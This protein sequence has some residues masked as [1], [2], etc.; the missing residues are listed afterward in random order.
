MDGTLVDNMRFHGAAWQK[1]L[2]ENGVETDASEFL[3]KTAG[4]TNREIIPH[5]FKDA[6]EERLLELGLRKET[7]YRELFLSERRAIHGAI[8]FLEASKKL[9]VKMAV[10][11]AAP[12]ANMEFVL[13]GLDLRRFFDAITTAADVSNGKPNPEVFLKSAEKLGIEPKHCLVFEDAVNGFAA[14]HRAGMKS[15]G[16]A[17]VNSIEDILKLDSVVEAHAD[18]S[19]L[20]PRELIE[21]YLPEDETQTASG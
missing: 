12:V 3:V 2:A 1:M 6:T 17:T 4:K 20:K 7:I 13:D 9:G 11:T 19:N 21:K 10:A 15:V 8:E 5:F 18:F 14:A 16:I